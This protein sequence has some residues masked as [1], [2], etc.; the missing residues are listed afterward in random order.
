MLTLTLNED[1]EV[2]IASFGNGRSMLLSIRDSSRNLFEKRL[3]AA[4][5]VTVPF[6]WFGSLAGLRYALQLDTAKTL[7]IAPSKVG[8]CSIR[9]TSKTTQ[10]VG[11]IL[12]HSTLLTSCLLCVVS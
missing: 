1:V 7:S 8:I 10:V 5:S 11:R 9:S 12:Q 3:F 4:F 2:L 6:V